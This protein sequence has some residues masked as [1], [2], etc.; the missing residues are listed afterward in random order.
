MTNSP[1]PPTAEHFTLIECLAE[2][3]QKSAA[4]VDATQ[5]EK[6]SVM[7]KLLVEN[8]DQGMRLLLLSYLLTKQ[9]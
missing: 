2:N 8:Y 6:M 3:L 5:P 1:P 9:K 7:G 4:L